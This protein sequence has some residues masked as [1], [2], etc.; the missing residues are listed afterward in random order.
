[1][2]RRIRQKLNI[3]QQHLLHKIVVAAVVICFLWVLFAPGMGFFSLRKQSHKMKKLSKEIE[4]LKDRNSTLQSEIDLL[5]TDLEHFEQ[6]A[7]EKYDL[8]EEDEV[9]YKLKKDK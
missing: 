7:R 1:M 8:V 4:E 9:L 5:K 2:R 3:R 6:V